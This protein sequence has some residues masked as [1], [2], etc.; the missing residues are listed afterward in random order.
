MRSSR[1]RPRCASAR[2]PRSR[3]ARSERV[4]AV[5]SVELQVADLAARLLE[6]LRKLSPG[7]GCVCPV[8]AWIVVSL[9]IGGSEKPASFS[10]A[11]VE[12]GSGAG[13]IPRA[14]GLRSLR[15][16]A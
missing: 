3:P 16:T 6:R 14:D 9:L 12:F 2:L 13:A 1:R 11:P 15:C 5:R 7:T 4:V 10:Y 8:R